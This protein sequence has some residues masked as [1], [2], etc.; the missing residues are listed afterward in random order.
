M[1]LNKAQINI[2][3]DTVSEVVD[4]WHLY[5]EGTV[6]IISILLDVEKWNIL[7]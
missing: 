7:I 2:T 3:S 4:F 5:Q 6:L 1:S